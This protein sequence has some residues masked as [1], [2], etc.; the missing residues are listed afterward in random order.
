MEQGAAPRPEFN[1]NLERELQTL[2]EDLTSP[3]SHEC[4]V[5]YVYRMLDFGCDGEQRWVR[6]YQ[7]VRAPRATA[8]SE[9]L[10][11]QGGF[12]DCEVL[13]NVFAANPAFIR[14]DEFGDPVVERKPPCQGVRAGSAQ[15]CLLWVERRRYRSMGGRF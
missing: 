7:D 8:L 4:L 2:T 15:P 13:L 6:R 3:R 14:W 12:C 1:A 10:M 11:R 9:R 5:C